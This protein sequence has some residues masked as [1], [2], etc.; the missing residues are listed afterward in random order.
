MK[1]VE[2]IKSEYLPK[3]TDLR[4]R[5]KWNQWLIVGST[6]SDRLIDND[7]L[8]DW[9]SIHAIISDLKSAKRYVAPV[10]S[11]FGQLIAIEFTALHGKAKNKSDKYLA[12]TANLVDR[13]VSK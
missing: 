5:A 13:K 7:E 8:N 6:T 4:E 10:D 3:M 2:D 11:R 1:T 9:K 12:V